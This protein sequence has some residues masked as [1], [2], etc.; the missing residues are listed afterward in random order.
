MVV[1]SVRFNVFPHYRAEGFTNL[2]V[3]FA[4][5]TGTQ[6]GVGEVGVHT[7]SV[8]VE[9][10]QWL[11]MPV[12]GNV[13]FLPHSFK[14]V[15]GNP[16]LVAGF[17]GAFGKNLELPLAGGHF[18]IDA[19][20]IKAGIQTGIQVLFYHLASKSIAGTYRTI[21]RSLGSGVT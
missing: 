16:D 9:V 6:E 12:D 1:G 18:G 5:A 7:T 15:A 8:P 4:A 2:F 14:Q 21:I 19:F 17:F 3:H 13:V 11:A 10:T 20:N